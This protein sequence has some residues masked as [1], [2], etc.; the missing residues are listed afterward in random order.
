MASGGYLSLVLTESNVNYQNNTSDVTA[1]LYI[2]ITNG[3]SH[4]YGS[5]PGTITI[6]GTSYSFSHSFTANSGAQLLATKTKT[7]THNSDGTKTVSASASFTTGVSLGTLT[8]SASKTLT[9][10]P[11]EST[12]TLADNAPYY[13]DPFNITINRN[14]SSYLH[15]VY[16]GNDNLD[17]VKIGN[18]VGTSLTYTIPKAY[19]QHINSQ[20]QGFWLKVET[21]NGNTLVGRKEYKPALYPK[22]TAD[23]CPEVSI[24]DSD[25]NGYATT[26]GGYVVGRSKVKVQLNE[27]LYEGASI[28]SRTISV[29][30]ETLSA[31][32]SISQIVTGASDKISVTVLDNRGGV[33]TVEKTINLISWNAPVVGLFRAERCNS[34]GTPQADGSYVKVSYA[35]DYASVDGRNTKSLKIKYKTHSAT[36]WQ[37]RTVSLAGQGYS[38]AGSDYFL[39]STTSA[40]DVKLEVGDYFTSIDSAVLSVGTGFELLNIHPNGKGVAFGKYAEDDHQEDFDIN[41]DVYMRKGLTC[42]GIDYSI[43]STEYNE[44]LTL[45]GGS[46]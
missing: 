20:G 21:F 46:D 12:I 6:D 8:A 35:I 27:S 38:V 41:M 39:A 2:Y 11:R 34:A 1:K 40:W 26:F 23:M 36:T 44:L 17:Y 42:G 13:G 4:N 45:L 15:D 9:A 18:R 43:S 33:A 3:Q 10:I 31:N 24:V 28:Q 16:I 37:T 14:V 32:P 19:V 29:N 22:L 25:P 5:Q 7:V 30:G